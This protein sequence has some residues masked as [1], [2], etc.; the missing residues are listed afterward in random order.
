M[1][2]GFFKGKN[3]LVM[4]LGRFAGG[5]DSAVFASRAGA[6]VTVTDLVGQD[7]LKASLEKLSGL[8][9]EY[10]LD[11]HIDADF[12]SADI[13]IVNPAVP[14]GSKYIELAENAG[15]LVTSQIEIFFQ[16]CPS[17]IVAIT[18]SNGKST[19]TAL[20][21]H[22]L[23]YDAAQSG[24]DFGKVWLS[25]NIG[26]EP[27]LRRLDEIQADDIAVLE[28]SSFQ[29]EQLARIRKGPNVAVITNLTPNHLD[30]HG[31]FEAYCRAKQDLFKF[32][33]LD[34]VKPAVSIFNAADP[35]TTG[36]YEKYSKETG[37]ICLK[38]STDDISKALGEKFKLAGRM[39]L[40]NLAA[41]T[42]VAKY[43]KV[44]QSRIESAAETFKP[45]PHR[46][47]LVAQIEG[48][49]WYDDSIST[50]P[51][52]TIAA[53]E[54]FDEPKI[55]IAGGYD[56]GLAF[57]ELGAAITHKAKAAVLIGQTA[58]AIIR[59]I[60]TEN[61]KIIVKKASTMARA[62]EIAG[63]LAQEGDVILLSPAC[64]SY[65]MFRNFQERAEVFCRLVQKL[66]R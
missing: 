64:A 42:A 29:I 28:I 66:N 19:T 44:D 47:E 45:L 55:I 43:F 22:L 27:L 56:K 7:E 40:S 3:V 33:E 57:D 52:S 16:L 62:I 65:D 50:T 20:T 12:Q 34:E 30:R 25:G 9:I 59:T 5:V 37:R 23:S 58:E 32:Q 46:L 24:A 54:A 36:W 41:A 8:D 61:G 14:P 35:I 31:T 38:F 11:G 13:V 10:H 60:N 15:A 17:R 63:E 2:K 1:N 21:H 26:N 39:N 53:L 48:V 18:G 51:V 49:R 4:G 6:K